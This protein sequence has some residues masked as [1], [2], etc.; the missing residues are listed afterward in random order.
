MARWD[1]WESSEVARWEAPGFTQ[2]WLTRGE[3]KISSFFSD[4]NQRN[5]EGECVQDIL[6]WSQGRKDSP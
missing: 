4:V 2:G 3:S 6:A 1:R 5:E